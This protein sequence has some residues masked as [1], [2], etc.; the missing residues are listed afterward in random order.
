SFQTSRF[1][2]RR[3]GYQNG[4]SIG[5][6][7]RGAIARPKVGDLSMKASTWV[8]ALVPLLGV[9]VVAVGCGAGGASNAGSVKVIAVWSG[10]E[11]AS[12]MAVLKPFEDST[13][14]KVQYESTRDEDAILR[15]R[16]A[17]V[18]GLI[19]YDPKNFSSK[20]YTVPKTWQD[21]LSLQSQIKSSG[22]PPWCIAVASGGAADG[23]PASDWLK[24]IVLSQAGPDV[25]DKWVA[26]KQT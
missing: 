24:E 9:I 7:Y 23:W 2:K 14:I 21:L 15:T 3:D 5:P 22:T 16:V 8:R 4:I 26:G 19:W 12:F 10:Q 17:A 25:Y 11:Q 20:G 6:V 18:K 13:G 1:A